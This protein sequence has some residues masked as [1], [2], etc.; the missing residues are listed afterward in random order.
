MQLCHRNL[1]LESIVLQKGLRSSVDSSDAS[2][3][4][5]YTCMIRDFG[6][7]ARV[8]CSADG[9]VVHMLKP[10]SLMSSC[11]LQYIAPEVWNGGNT[12]DHESGPSP[13]DAYAADLWSAGVILLAL[14]FGTDA[15][16][17]APVPEDRVFKQICIDRH[18]KEIATH[19]SPSLS[20]NALDL[21]QRLLRCD[22]KDRPTLADVQQ[23]P[24]V[25]GD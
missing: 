16:F 4:F 7:A 17:V 3:K 8:P 21:L 22:P 18:L 2:P 9:T 20:D 24:W 11:N 23:H 1:S 13:F 19:R 10:L 12:D 15:I 14:L 6:C 25:I 5:G